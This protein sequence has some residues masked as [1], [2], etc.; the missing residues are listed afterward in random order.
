VNVLSL[1]SGI[2][3]L[4]LGLEWAG[5]T[6]VGQ[7]ELDPFCRSVLAKHWPEV[8]RHD[9]VRTCVEWW[10][11]EPRPAVHV[12]CGGFP[13]QPFS[14]AGERKG[15]A[16]E[17]WGW[18]WY[19]DVIRALRPRFV[20]VENVAA[21]LRDS[22]AFGWILADLATLGY[23][24]EWDCIPAAAVGAHHRRDRLFLVAYTYSKVGGPSTRD[25]LTG[26]GGG[27]V[28]ERPAES[29]GRGSAVADATGDR[30]GQPGPGRPPCNGEDRPQ[31]APEPLERPGVFRSA[32]ERRRWPA[33]PAVGRMA[34]GL[35]ARV[36]QPQL[37]GLGNAVVPQVSEYIGR[38]VMAHAQSEVPA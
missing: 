28:R 2:G 7:V 30:R 6:V 32:P 15:I 11:S 36:A 1:F 33:E 37:R 14:T 35:S 12:V 3:G 19:F 25:A 21:L 34:H 31:L 27:A 16:D 17:R 23:D 22:D 9:D 26:V 5:M 18:P 10:G 24:A 20:I 13:C 38:L 8:P 4:E 29:G